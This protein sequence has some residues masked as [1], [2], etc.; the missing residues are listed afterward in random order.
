MTLMFNDG[1]FTIVEKLFKAL[2]K[3][4]QHWRLSLAS[5]LFYILLSLLTNVSRENFLVLATNITTNSRQYQKPPHSPVTTIWPLTEP[6]C[7]GV[8]SCYIVTSQKDVEKICNLSRECRTRSCVEFNIE[9]CPWRTP[10][11]LVHVG[12]SN[13]DCLLKDKD[14]CVSCMQDLLDKNRK[15]KQ[16]FENY[17]SILD[18]YDCDRNYS[19]YGCKDCKIAYRD[20]LCGITFDFYDEG[21]LIKPCLE[22]CYETSR[23]CPFLLPSVQY[24]GRQSYFCPRHRDLYENS[25]YAHEAPCFQCDYSHKSALGK[26]T[27][28]VT[29]RTDPSGTVSLY[30]ASVTRLVIGQLAM[31]WIWRTFV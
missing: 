18:R 31:L 25:T 5:L 9:T 19:M 1:G 20:W 11:N 4:L 23:K 12:N 21:R 17:A 7:R 27:V 14:G 16:L 8:Q 24:C 10:M 6:N 26:C 30:K 22:F 3:I 28:N 29:N 2:R 15:V 13:S